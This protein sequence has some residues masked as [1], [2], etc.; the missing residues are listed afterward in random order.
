M[1]V[2]RV[3][4]MAVPVGLMVDPAVQGALEVLVDLVEEVVL[5]ALR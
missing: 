4:L 1:T 5:A 2:V 3:D